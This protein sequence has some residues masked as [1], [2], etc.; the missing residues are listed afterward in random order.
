MTD[1]VS[2]LFSEAMLNRNL[3]QNISFHVSKESIELL[4]YI[5]DGGNSLFVELECGEMS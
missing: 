5:I 4:K 3:N 1:R 2:G